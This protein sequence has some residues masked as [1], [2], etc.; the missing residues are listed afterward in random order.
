MMLTPP[1]PL[2]HPLWSLPCLI[3]SQL[4]MSNTRASPMTRLPCWRGS[5]EPFFSSTR[6]GGDHLGAASSA[7]TLPT[8][9]PSAPRGRSSTPPPTSLTTPSRTTPARVTTRRSMASRTRRSSRRS[10]HENVLPLA[11]L[12]SPVMTPPARTRMRRSSPRKATSLAFAL[13]ANLLNTSLTLI[14]M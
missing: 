13:W 1:T 5:T 14:L 6:R 12:T 9:S 7:V 8:S 10:C 11:I 4:L 3:W 2:S